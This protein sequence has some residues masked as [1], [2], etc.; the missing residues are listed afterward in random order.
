MELNT[1]ECEREAKE[2][3]HEED[4]IHTIV[5]TAGTVL[6]MS[7][8]KRFP[9]EQLRAWV[10][11]ILNLILL[12]I[13][14]M[15]MRPGCWVR[16]TAA[17]EGNVDEVKNGK[18]EKSRPCACSQDIEEGKEWYKEQCWTSDVHV[19]NV[20][21]EEAEEELVGEEEVLP[22]HLKE[23]LNGRVE[24]FIVMFKQH[25]VSDAKQAENFRIQKGSNMTPKA[26]EY[27]VEE[28]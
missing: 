1:W 14:F 17:S 27:L 16:S 7:C 11:L 3:G 2:T 5:I 10:F 6:L 15:S 18:A 21:D 24:A 22:R 20:R 8:L 4:A 28:A 19:Q 26:M 13:I 25:L 9:V 23:E 12:A